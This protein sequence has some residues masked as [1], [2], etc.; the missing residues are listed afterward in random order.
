L[1]QAQERE[2]AEAIYPAGF[3]RTKAARLKEIGRILSVQ[4]GGTVPR[5]ESELLE[6]PG[7][8]RKTANLVLSLG[9]GLPA[10]CVDTHVHRISNRL[11]WVTSRSPEETE[12]QLQAV[13]P[14]EYWR[15]INGLLVAFGQQTCTPTSPRCSSC[16]LAQTCP[17]VGVTKSR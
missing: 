9:F 2:I 1:A 17:M 12:R 16:P 10:I 11:G 3:Y 5:S 4:Y 8:G 6:L 13:L 7:V 15:E 14:K